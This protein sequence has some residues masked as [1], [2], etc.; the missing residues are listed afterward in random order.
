MRIV[1]KFL[2]IFEEVLNFSIDFSLLT[3]SSHSRLTNFYQKRT[4]P[5]QLQAHRKLSLSADQPKIGTCILVAKC[6]ISV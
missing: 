4:K 2:L 5:A 3:P 6:Q 1:F